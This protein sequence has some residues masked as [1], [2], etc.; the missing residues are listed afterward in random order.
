MEGENI[1]FLSGRDGSKS[2][3]GRATAMDSVIVNSKNSMRHK[4]VF[5][6]QRILN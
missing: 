3:G 4:I 6:L 2:C 5:D 1:C